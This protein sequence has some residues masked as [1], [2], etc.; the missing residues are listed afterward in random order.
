MQKRIVLVLAILLIAGLAAFAQHAAATTSDDLFAGVDGSA[1]SAEEMK[2]VEGEG[3]Q[4]AL[5]FA[6]HYGLT[7]FITG[8]GAGALAGGLG[9]T[10]VVPVLGTVT[11]AVAV[12]IASAVSGGLL[13]AVSGIVDGWL[14]PDVDPAIVDLQQQLLIQQAVIDSLCNSSGPSNDVGAGK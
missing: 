7:G 13:G 12:G 5:I 10:F 4:N 1:L 11:G 14:T 9:G 6:L 2:A 3:P 8:G